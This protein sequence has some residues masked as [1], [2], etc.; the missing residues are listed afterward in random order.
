MIMRLLLLLLL[1][2]SFVSEGLSMG[3]F[4]NNLLL[5]TLGYFLEEFVIDGI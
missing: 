5:E 2:L 4:G 3:D 1:D